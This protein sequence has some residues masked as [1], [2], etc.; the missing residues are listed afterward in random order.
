M[1]DDAIDLQLLCKAIVCELGSGWSNHVIPECLRGLRTVCKTAF[2]VPQYEWNTSC[3]W[4]K[5]LLEF[6]TWRPS[7]S[8]PSDQARCEI[9]IVHPTLFLITLFLNYSSPSRVCFAHHSNRSVVSLAL[10]QPMSFS[11]LFPPPVMS[12]RGIDRAT[13]WGSCRWPRSTHHI[14]KVDCSGKGQQCFCMLSEVL[15]SILIIWA[16]K[17]VTTQIIYS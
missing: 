6:H 12:R 13:G 17:I 16:I 15:Q 9:F 7:L 14:N 10:S 3:T 1:D 2:G 8:S 5:L 4:R 11:I